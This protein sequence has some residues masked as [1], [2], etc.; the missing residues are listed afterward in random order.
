MVVNGFY[1]KLPDLSGLGDFVAVRTIA[2]LFQE[3]LTD[4]LVSIHPEHPA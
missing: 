1:K 3:F 4:L 2:L